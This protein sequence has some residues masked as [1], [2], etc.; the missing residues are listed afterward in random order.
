MGLGSGPAATAGPRASVSLVLISAGWFPL[1][2]TRDGRDRYIKA[3]T[4]ADAGDLKPLIRLVAEL[5]R[6]WFLR[7][8]S[9]AEGHIAAV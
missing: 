6:K 1:V 5:E 8:L 3:L 7:T 2:V 4:T 9:I